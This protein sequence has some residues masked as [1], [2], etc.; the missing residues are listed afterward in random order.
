MLRDPCP[1]PWRPHSQGV[2]RDE[3]SETLNLNGHTAQVSGVAF[4]P[5]GKRIASGSWDNTVKVWDATSGQRDPHS[6]R[7]RDRVP[8]WRSVPMANG[9][10]AEVRTNGEG[11]GCD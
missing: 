3:R 7:A 11:V 10:S 8:A 1:W 2:G 9:S 6:Q 5:D 4:S